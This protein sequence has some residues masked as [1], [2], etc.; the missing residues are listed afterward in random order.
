MLL[1]GSPVITTPKVVD[2]FLE[3]DATHL[4]LLCSYEPGI[5]LSIYWTRNGKYIDVTNTYDMSTGLL[6]LSKPENFDNLFGTYQCFVENIHGTDYT[7]NRILVKC[8]FFLQYNYIL[9]SFFGTC[10]SIINCYYKNTKNTCVI[11]YHSYSIPVIFK[12]LFLF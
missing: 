2:I 11:C 4:E 8:Q 7:I 3:Y 6:R 1:L 12:L 9:G 5:P 10:Q